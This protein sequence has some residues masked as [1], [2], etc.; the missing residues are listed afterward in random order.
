[1]KVERQKK[2]SG[3]GNRKGGIYTQANEEITKNWKKG[4]EQDR[5]R[6]RERERKAERQ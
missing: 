3:E 4:I 5:E 1:M 6:E 2:N